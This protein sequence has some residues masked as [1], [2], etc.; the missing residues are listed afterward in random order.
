MF[1]SQKNFELPTPLTSSSYEPNFLCLSKV[2]YLSNIS[3]IRTVSNVVVIGWRRWIARL[4]SK[5]CVVHD[6]KH[7][8]VIFLV[9]KLQGGLRWRDCF[10]VVHLTARSFCVCVPPRVVSVSLP[11]ARETICLSYASFHV[12]NTSSKTCLSILTSCALH[13]EMERKQE[14]KTR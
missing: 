10:R 4:P 8:S 6:L 13:R 9:G 5:R 1:G 7:W 11:V 14:Q 2:S 3:P 12:K